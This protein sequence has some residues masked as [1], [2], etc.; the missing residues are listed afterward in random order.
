MSIYIKKTSSSG[1][2]KSYTNNTVASGPYLLQSFLGAAAS[3][4]YS[5]RKLK[6]DYTGSAIRVRRSSDNTE[7][8]IGF[9]S[10]MYLDTGSLLSF[11]GS[12]HGFVTK[13]YDQ[14]GLAR[15][16]V[17]ATVT[18]QPTIV[19]TG[20]L[21]S[22]GIR[23]AVYFDGSGRFLS[24]VFSGTD[25]NNA[26]FVARLTTTSVGPIYSLF[27]TRFDT[28]AGPPVLGNTGVVRVNGTTY[29]NATS[30]AQDI[31]DLTYGTT[32][33]NQGSLYFNGSIVSTANSASTY[34]IGF[35]TTGRYNDL[36]IYGGIDIGVNN[37]TNRNWLGNIQEI[38]YWANNDLSAT[39]LNIENNLNN[40]YRVYSGYDTS[41]ISPVIGRLKLM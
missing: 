10:N 30:T 6:S 15:D 35:V 7:Q 14:S 18:Y 23:P 12:G 25:L 32:G 11:V 39:R 38:I 28:I 19:L 22:E 4:A 31:R 40:Y 26:S 1:S 21:S 27:G 9:I 5:L 24:G 29:Y 3:A 41:S 2:I 13:W 8:D 16:A 36:R 37:A 20:S 34:H 17:Q 33:A